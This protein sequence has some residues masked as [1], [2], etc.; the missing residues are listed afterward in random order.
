MYDK[1]QDHKLYVW[2]NKSSYCIFLISADKLCQ[3]LIC[4]PLNLK[5][6]YSDNIKNTLLIYGQ[7]DADILSFST[8]PS[9]MEWNIQYHTVLLISAILSLSCRK[10]L[11]IASSCLVSPSCVLFVTGCMAIQFS[12]FL[13]WIVE[14]QMLYN[15][16]RKRI[17]RGSHVL[18]GQVQTL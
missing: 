5:E 3:C 6:E 11:N 9:T 1:R 10:S 15:I 18:K 8:L 13:S 14:N 7:F 16:I 4:P 12:T 2:F 17:T